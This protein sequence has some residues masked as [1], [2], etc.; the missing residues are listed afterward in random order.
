ML[1]KFYL[2]AGLIAHKAFWEVLKRRAGAGSQPK[3]PA[4]LKVKLVKL[5]KIGILLGIMAQVFLPDILPITQDPADL[6]LFGTILYTVGLATAIAGRAY[7]GD[8]W[9]DIEVPGQ[10]AKPQLVS[11]GLYRYIRHPIYTGDMLLLI[12]LELALNS[13]FVLLVLV[14]M[15]VIM[16]QTLREEKLLIENLPGYRDYC[17]RT[18]RFVPFVA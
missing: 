11:R 14:M 8:S 7:L 1:L 4:P 15:P 13:W 2:L 6:R 9:S 3:P 5:V 12:G 17:A 10:V 16:R 18:K